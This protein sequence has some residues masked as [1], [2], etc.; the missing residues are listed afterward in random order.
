MGLTF[1]VYSVPQFAAAAICA[2]LFAVTA[3]QYRR[4]GA[5][6]LLG[7]FAGASV[8]AASYGLLLG[9]AAP[10]RRLLW[11][12]IGILGFTLATLSLFVFAIQYTG[13]QSFV[14][15][16]LVGALAV[17]PLVTNVLVWTNG[18]HHLV[19]SLIY[20]VE[21]V[22][23]PVRLQI[24]WGPWYYVH[25]GYSVLLGLGTLTLF[26]EKLLRYGESPAAIWQTRSLFVAAA[27]PLVAYVV[28]LLGLIRVNVAPIGFAVGGTFVLVAILVAPNDP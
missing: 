20:V 15:P 3:P 26:T 9:T 28:H 1:T 27:T 4:Q 14:T 18:A 11:A 22:G 12:N 21:P 2:S 7:L 13:R 16:T 5:V 24:A 19:R 10:A 8:W 25:V 23:T 17:I 6:P